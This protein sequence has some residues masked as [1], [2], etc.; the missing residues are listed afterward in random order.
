MN[1]SISFSDRGGRVVGLYQPGYAV[2]R[3]THLLGRNR[4]SG[5]MCLAGLTVVAVAVARWPHVLARAAGK[6]LPFDVIWHVKTVAPVVGLS[7]DDGP[8]PA[9]TPALL[10]VLARHHAH[11]TFFIIGSRVA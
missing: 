7:F 10:E 6:V 3:M 9:T 5:L 11:A 1:F 2:T 8:S 4:R